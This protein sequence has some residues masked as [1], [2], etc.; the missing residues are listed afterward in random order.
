MGFLTCASWV[1]VCYITPTKHFSVNGSYYPKGR[2][3]ERGRILIIAGILADLHSRLQWPARTLCIS[4]IAPARK[5]L[6]QILNVEPKDSTS[7][8]IS[9][10]LTPAL[11]EK[12]KLLSGEAVM[13]AE[14]ESRLALRSGDAA[15]PNLQFIALI[16]CGLES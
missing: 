12:T 9:L 11:V 13:D 14:M 8:R 1:P 5:M 7:R 15:C 16:F 3:G 6:T 4:S 2:E 10:N